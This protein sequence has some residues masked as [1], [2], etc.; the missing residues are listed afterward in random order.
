M[1]LKQVYPSRFDGDKYVSHITCKEGDILVNDEG[2]LIDAMF[3]KIK[4]TPLTD[5][6]FGG[7]CNDYLC[8]EINKLCKLSVFEK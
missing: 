3:A 2:V 1:N 6:L 8:S 7:V 4:T 5:M